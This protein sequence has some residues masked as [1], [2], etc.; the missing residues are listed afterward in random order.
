MNDSHIQVGDSSDWETLVILA[1]KEDP[2]LNL[3]EKK[4]YD[5]I[6][7]RGNDNPVDALNYSGIL[8]ANKE[9]ERRKLYERVFFICGDGEDFK[10]KG[11]PGRLKEFG[12]KPFNKKFNPNEYKKELEKNAI[13][14]TEFFLQ[15]MIQA[16]PIL[17]R[18]HIQPNPKFWYSDSLTFNIISNLT[19]RLLD[20]DDT[21]KFFTFLMAMGIEFRK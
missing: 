17:N 13:Y 21:H 11:V 4:E 1:G 16:A 15:E 2:A 12:F 10:P 20:L 6:D 7:L 8:K 14:T 18:C 9:V 19:S 5:I 3:K